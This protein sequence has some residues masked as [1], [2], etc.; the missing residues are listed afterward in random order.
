MNANTCH[1]HAE[2][3]LVAFEARL[4]PLEPVATTHEAWA[5]AGFTGVRHLLSFDVA[6]D[7]DVARFT[8]ELGDAELPL[9]GAFVAD[10][11][12]T[13]ARPHHGRVRLDVE[14]L[15]IDEA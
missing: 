10:V 4:G 15:V 11:T 13:R 7:A 1:C 8:L 5:S 14:A 3:L 12:V 2:A 6:A 9:P